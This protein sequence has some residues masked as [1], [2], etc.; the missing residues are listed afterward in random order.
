M[1]WAWKVIRSTMAATSRASVATFPHSL[2]GRLEASATDDFSS[3]SVKIWNNG[4]APRVSPGV[5]IAH[6]TL[7]RLPGELG[8]LLPLLSSQRRRDVLVGGEVG[9]H[10]SVFAGRSRLE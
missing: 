2:N 4:S 3:R 10:G 6:G 7:G 5:S 8:A 9:D 1:T